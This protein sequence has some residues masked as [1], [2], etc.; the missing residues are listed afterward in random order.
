MKIIEKTKSMVNKAVEKTKKIF[1]ILV[2]K[3]MYFLNKENFTKIKLILGVFLSLA[4]AVVTEYT[5]MRIYHP[6]FISKNRMMILA[7]IYMFVGIHFVFKLST[8]YEWI[9]KNRYKIACAFLL[10]VTIFRYSGSSI[11]CF[12]EYLG[13]Q[14][15]SDDSRYHT[16]L[17]KVRT[18]RT[19]EWATSTTYILSQGEGA[20]QFDYYSDKLRGTQTDMFTVSNSPVLDILMLGRPFQL[21]FLLLGNDYGWSF[22]WNIRLVAMML[23]AYEFCLI[24]TKQNKKMSLLGMIM[25]TFSAAV[26]WWYCMDTLIWGQIAVVLIDKFMNVDKKWQKY[27]CAFGILVAG[28]SY[29][30]VFYPAWQL[31]FGYMFLAIV[32]W[33]LFKNIKYGSYRFT[34]HDIAV[35][36]VTLLCLALLLCRWYMMSGDTLKAVMSTDYPGNR[37]EVGGGALNNYSYFYNIYFPFEDFLNPCEFSG[38]LSLYPVPLILGLIYVLRN[39]KDLHFWI[40][41]LVMGGFLSV[42]CVYG[43]PAW[44]ANLTKMSMATAGRATIPLGTLSIYA[45]IYLM[46]NIK[47]DEKLIESRNIKVA[48][49]G[50]ITILIAYQAYTT[51]GYKDIFRYLDKF[52]MLVSA[53]IFVAIIYGVLNMKDEK[54]K[55]YTMYGLIAVALISGLTVNPLIR[56]T[57]IFYTKP[58]AR[59]IQEIRDS[60]PDALW[61]VNS[62]NWYLNDYALANGVRVINSTNIYPNLELYDEIAGDKKAEQRANYNRYAHVNLNVVSDKETS[63][64]LLHADNIALIMNAKDLDDYEIEYILSKESLIEKGL[65]EYVEE[66]YNEDGMYIYQVIKT[67]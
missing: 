33:M 8:M 11:T 17:G 53:E 38:M 21:G 28:L 60:N 6:Q 49:A 13:L 14:P 56:T 7:M 23:G 62:D 31:T 30:F 1:N 42:W 35:I 19:D 40:P 67:Q 26:Q 41:T 45:L 39:R 2:Q 3:T 52:K 4:A 47:K 29:V 25:I 51:I 20:N 61:A 22:Y 18:I 63:I 43:F 54:I 10:F 57:D 58:V 24:L 5:V 34:K 66:I 55:N 27:L 32:I 59:K 12:H 37:V 65:Q 50:L 48:F 16:L 44:F 9:H 46:A 64:E 15:Q 36:V